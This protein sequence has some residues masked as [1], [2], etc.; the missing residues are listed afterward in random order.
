MS[1]VTS[2]PFITFVKIGVVDNLNYLQC[3][4]FQKTGNLG[5]LDERVKLGLPESPK[6][7]I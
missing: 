6:I 2:L 3:Y 4:S 1:T 5:K 7:W